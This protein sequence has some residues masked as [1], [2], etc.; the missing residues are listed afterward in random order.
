MQI[1]YWATSTAYPFVICYSTTGFE[2]PIKPYILVWYLPYINSSVAPI[3]NKPNP[4]A[5][6]TISRSELEIHPTSQEAIKNQLLEKN[7]GSTIV[8][9]SGGH[10]G[11]KNSRPDNYQP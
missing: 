10:G 9:V 5:H 8:V 2:Y 3:Q 1:F 6:Q 11:P 7:A 4:I